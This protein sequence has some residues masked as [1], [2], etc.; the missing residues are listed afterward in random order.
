MVLVLSCQKIPVLSPVKKDEQF[1]ELVWNLSYIVWVLPPEYYLLLNNGL[2]CVNISLGGKGIIS[3][4]VK[5]NVNYC[6]PN[7]YYHNI[8]SFLH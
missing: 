5:N 4:E 6:K 3:Q 1:F 2:A 7:H 8:T